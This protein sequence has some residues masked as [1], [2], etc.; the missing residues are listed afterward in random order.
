MLMIAILIGGVVCATVMK[1]EVFPEF[2]LDHVSV[3]VLYPG[4]G[5]AEIEEGISIKVEEAVQGIP[6]IKKINSTSRE[7]LSSV[8]I[9]LKANVKDT[10]KVQ[11]DIR[12]AVERV[13]TFPD[14]A[15]RPITEELVLRRQVINIAIYGDASE[16]TLKEIGRSVKDDLLAMPNISQVGWTGIREYEIHVEV[17]ES[18]LRKYSL[19]FAHVA[20]AV[21]QGSVNLPGGTIRGEREDIKLNTEGRKY[22]ASEYADIVVLARPDGTRV[23]LGQMARI[24]DGFEEDPR[25]SRFNSKPSVTVAVHKTSD[26]DAIDIA[27]TVRE[28]C[29]ERAKV[30]PEGVSVESW[31]D[32][33]TFITGRLSLL[34]KNARIGIILVFLCLWLFLNGRLSFWVALGIPVS[35]AGGLIFM[36]LTGQTINMIS[37]FALIMVMGIVVD[38]AIIVG[39]NV[40]AFVRRGV[41]VSRA[42]VDATVQVNLP[43]IA[44][45]LTTVFT[46]TPLL[47]VGG[48]MGKFIR[49]LPLAVIATLLASL[50]ECFLILPA[51]L[52]H[53]KVAD[54]NTPTR[55]GL[56]G[57]PLAVRKRVDAFIEHLIEKRYRRV[58]VA[59]LRNRYV[60]IS[61]ALFSLL[62]VAGVFAGGLVRY[63]L[64]PKEDSDFMSAS[65]VFPAGT[66]QEVTEEALGRME[67]AVIGLNKVF[68]DKAEGKL[69]RQVAASFGESIMGDFTAGTNV[70]EV[71][72]QLAAAEE[73]R[74][75]SEE[76]I[77][78]WRAKTGPI[79]DAISVVFQ[80]MHGGPAGKPI[81]IQL[82]ADDA[83]TLRQ[84]AGDLKRKLADYAGAS[85]ITDDFRPGKR[86]FRVELKPQGR[87]LGI[88]LLELARQLRQGFF[89]EEVLR[90]QRGRDDVKV[91]IRYPRDERRHLSD[92][93]NVRIR[94]PAGDEVPFGEVASVSLDREPAAIRRQDGKR[95]ITVSAD[96][97]ETVT[98]AGA[99]VADLTKEFLPGFK[100]RYGGLSVSMEGQKQETTEALGGLIITFPMALLAVFAVLAIQFRSY[101]KPLVIMMAI[102]F[103]IVGAVLGHFVMGKDLTLLS[104]F[105]LV[106]VSGVVVND[107]LV[108]IDFVNRNIREGMTVFDAVKEAGPARFRAIVLTSTTTIAGLAPLVL[109]KSFQA[110]FLIPM[111]VSITWGLAVATLINLFVTPSIYLALNDVRRLLYM[112][113]TGR[114]P[115]AEEMEPEV[116]A[117]SR[118]AE[119]VRAHVPGAQ[120]G[121]LTSDEGDRGGQAC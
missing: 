77:N 41:P 84:A 36:Q 98:N 21:R 83:D 7:S 86:E 30:L 10:R 46:F 57:W 2:S 92:V 97:D 113:F 72:V 117:A 87:L 37:L 94:T 12:D 33:S 90:I 101:S 79:P 104:V 11:Y 105:G 16:G 116:D 64:F 61:I 89:G 14:D 73:R 17:S 39:E 45:V 121:S 71:L 106:A 31:M 76:V 55:P 85:D 34:L 110:Q 66:P 44:S 63:T 109:E 49:V 15:E 53:V 56:R 67:S 69:V 38:D 60:T 35:F 22:L 52:R 4:A 70:G 28:Y 108:L 3:A 40:Y 80:T 20:A 102:P 78:A 118:G 65:V 24:T 25:Y 8:L 29:Q 6:G 68:A 93:E 9:E 96:I 111:A 19:S 26:E 50:A 58:F 115:T 120:E 99:I 54:P 23:R 47:F 59:A 95:V 75:Q 43:V 5:P 91:R 114:W 107:A 88:T 82:R 18:A 32:T 1:T 119:G 100:D 81:E 51:H 112:F 27:R 62:V 48:V 74:V 103:G 13:E 42:I